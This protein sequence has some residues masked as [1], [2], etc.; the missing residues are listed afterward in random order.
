MDRYDVLIAGA[1]P[2]GMV[3]ALALAKQGIRVCIIDK[4]DGPGATSRAM[5]VQARTLEL[6]RPLGLA[7]EVANA[8]RPN[9]CI[10]LWVRGKRRAQLALRDAGA[11]LTPYPYVLIYP[12]DRHEALLERHLEAAGVTVRRRTELAAF[13]DR[14]D[15]VL[16]TL[17]SAGGENLQL[18]ARYLAGCDGARSFVRRQLGTGFA[19]GTYDHLFYVADVQARGLAANGE[20][21]LS[22]ETSDFVILLGYDDSGRGRLVGTVRDDRGEAGALSFND[23]SH[24]A[25]ASLGLE[26]EQVHW[27][28]TYRVH[29]RVTGHYRK[30]R[31]FL[32]GDAAHVHSPAGGQGMNTGI[33]DAINLAWKLAAVVRGEAPD[34]LL[35]SYERERIAF[36]RKLVDT[37]DRLFSF[38]TLDSGFADFIRT[39]IAPTF[40]SAAYAIG[41]VRE[42]I[43]RILSQTTINYHDSPLSSGVA[44]RVQGGD[45]LPWV[46]REGQ[47]NY[48][49]PARID[50]Q[51]HVYGQAYPDLRAW[52]DRH[53][54]MLRE[55]DWGREHDEAGLAR[56][57]A[58]LLR[59]DGYV[60][61]CDPGASAQALEDYFC[62]LDYRRYRVC[63]PKQVAL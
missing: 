61:L 44:G 14:D 13:E 32:L 2:T 18:E 59:P 43:F 12:Q 5:A 35:D 9:P 17:R 25:M 49:A 36:A 48:A 55:F 26:V 20:I 41:P 57:A 60:A 23:V 15:H 40:A 56:N 58:Y 8:G 24:R 52:C 42:M 53:G 10:N 33:G 37:T 1:G 47:D 3:L 11:R 29:H 16:A 19:G 7:D 46:L 63:E 39:R 6:Y 34:G 4:A 45:R 28:S 38:V 50:W 30:G 22:L 31:A 21:H 27:F 51:V 62:D 54:M